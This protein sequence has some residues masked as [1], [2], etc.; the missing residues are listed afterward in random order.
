MKTKCVSGSKPH[1]SAVSQ[2]KKNSAKSIQA[3]RYYSLIQVYCFHLKKHVMAQKSR[4][5]GYSLK[6][7]NHNLQKKH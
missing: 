5:L 7:R 4:V 1:S 3:K 2:S 6:K